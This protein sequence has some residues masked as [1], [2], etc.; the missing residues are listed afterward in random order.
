[1]H[2]H[3]APLLREAAPLRR[4]T[5]LGAEGAQEGRRLLGPLPPRQVQHLHRDRLRP[6]VQGGRG[7][8]IIVVSE[9]KFHI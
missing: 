6:Q 4:G 3:G 8:G 2:L 9:L 5:R 7:A 1:M